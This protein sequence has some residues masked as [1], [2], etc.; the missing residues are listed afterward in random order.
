MAEN[1][2]LIEPDKQI[3]FILS[4]GAVALSLLPYNKELCDKIGITKV[5]FKYLKLHFKNNPKQALNDLLTAIKIKEE[6]K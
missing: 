3:G 6:V 1:S 5:Q 2:L 4:V